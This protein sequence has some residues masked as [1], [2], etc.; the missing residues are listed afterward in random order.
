MTVKDIEQLQV[1]LPELSM[2]TSAT[3]L[4]SIAQMFLTRSISEGDSQNV[5]DNVEDRLVV[6]VSQ[7][8]LGSQLDKTLLQPAESE[9]DGKKTSQNKEDK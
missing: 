2:S 4:S 5:K 9:E 8:G 7:I 1:H 3:K 6:A